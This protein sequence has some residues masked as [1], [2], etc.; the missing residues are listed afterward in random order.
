MILSKIFLGLCLSS[1]LFVSTF[2]S[3]F[4]TTSH[5]CSNL[6]K[7]DRQLFRHE[8][9]L[10]RSYNRR[11]NQH[12]QYVS[13]RRRRHYGSKVKGKNGA[14][15]N[16]GILIK[17]EKVAGWGRRRKRSVDTVCCEEVSVSSVAKASE[18][19]WDRLGVYS[20]NGEIYN[21]RIDHSYSRCSYRQSFSLFSIYLFDL[22]WFGS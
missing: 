11:R 1:S 21:G 7:L 14:A 5:F 10:C 22:K 19:Q 2:R 20:A 15:S 9:I 17:W 13:N 8:F 4:S 6:Q 12:L 3:R 16:D 18:V